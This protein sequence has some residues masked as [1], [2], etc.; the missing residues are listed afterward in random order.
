[1][2][3]TYFIDW[4]SLSPYL[5]ISL[6]LSHSPWRFD[7]LNKVAG[8]FDLEP[9]LLGFGARHPQRFHVQLPLPSLFMHWAVNDVANYYG[10]C[11]LPNVDKVSHFERSTSPSWVWTSWGFWGD[12]RSWL[13]IQMHSTWMG[14]ALH[15]RFDW[16]LRFWPT[17]LIVMAF[18]RL[19]SLKPIDPSAPCAAVVKPINNSKA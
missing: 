11:R 5:P 7:W 3:K 14:I 17:L 19:I 8:R 2:Y 12:V 16:L 9:R 15:G 18:H 6:S 13:L 10:N 1:M 4:F